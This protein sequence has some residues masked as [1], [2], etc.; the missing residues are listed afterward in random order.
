MDVRYI[1]ETVGETPLVGLRRLY[2]GPSTVL[3]KLEGANPGGSVKDRAAVTML[4]RAE[5]RGTVQP[6]DRLI[7]A[8]SGNTGIGLAFAA[9][10]LGY[11]L[12]V[13]IP[14]HLGVERRSVMRAY[15]AE[16]RVV[17]KDVGMEGAI[18]L[19]H[20]LQA[21]GNGTV[22]N[23]YDNPDNSS[24]HFDT[25]GPEIWKQTDGSVTHFVA[26]LG[27]TGTVMGTGAYLRTRR[28]SIR[29]VAVRPD[30]QGG[31]PGIRNWT[32]NYTPA[33]Y[34]EDGVDEFR[35]VSRETAVTCMRRLA[36]E[37]GILAGVSTGANVAT[38]IDIASE[39][40]RA[41][42]EPAVVV[43]IVCDRG[44]RYLSSGVFGDVMH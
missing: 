15:G 3:L 1:D 22:L 7:E 32:S 4:R 36:A 23:Q 37:E 13:I 8:T 33:I 43:A 40:D 2:S 12:T 27:T 17:P 16:V 42:E 21:A 44:D 14:E 20:E 30:A 29:I 9:A 18:A 34:D 19:A 11:H 5:A 28:S 6:G 38:A 31:I 26:A 24:A 25:T 10:A 39:I 41:G 35:I